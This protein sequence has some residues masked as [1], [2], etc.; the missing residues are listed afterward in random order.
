ML[1]TL[2]MRRQGEFEATIMGS[3][4]CGI[5]QHNTRLKMKYEVMIECTAASRDRR[6][7]LFDQLTVNNYFLTLQYEVRSC[8]NI[9]VEAA[10]DLMNLIHTENPKC[11]VRSIHV[12]I[13]AAPYLAE[14]RYLCEAPA[15]KYLIPEDFYKTRTGRIKPKKPL[16]SDFSSWSKDDVDDGPF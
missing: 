14:M 8:E 15:R 4:H 2:T 1:E 7:F 13:S 10:R 3:E 12:V 6:G 5:G 11:K 16:V 9:A